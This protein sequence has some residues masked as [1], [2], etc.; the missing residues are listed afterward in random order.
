[1]R[2]TWTGES[3]QLMKILIAGLGS[4]GRRH[5]R[6]LLTLGESNILLYRTHQSTLPDEELKDFP[7]V[8]DL[9]AALNWN[10][11]AVIVSNPTALHLQVAI[12][13]AE[14]G[15]HLLIE[16][17]ISHSMEGVSQLSASVQ[18]GGGQVL[19]GY[20]FRF[21]PG[22][23][24]I[25]KLLEEA[26]IGR[27]LS[28]KAHWGEYLPGWHPWEDYRKGY[29]ARSELGGGVILTLSHPLDYLRWLVG[30]VSAVWALAGNRSDLA[31]DV[32][33][34]AEIGLQFA[35]GVLGSLH[36]DYN[37]RPAEH[38]LEIIGTQG[39]LRWDNADGAVRLYRASNTPPTVDS[40]AQP[41]W[42]V[43]PRPP[44]FDRNHLFLSEMEHFLQAARGE[45]QPLC[46]L[47]DGIQALRLSL[48]AARSANEG[49]LVYL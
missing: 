34:T 15:C 28:V 20:Q 37:Q 40:Q 9:Q 31:L 42:E 10:P 30:E 24:V 3:P 44:G 48:A 33:D 27:V 13:A 21:H 11:Q 35:D 38:R 36:L 1:M 14:A 46:S 18:R 7:A 32:E 49:K 25:S 22:L 39:S 47:D 29:S 2:K 41:A 6:N 16:K 17:P 23:Q 4:I 26:A 5:L 43:V 8:T 19:V 45:A 12:P